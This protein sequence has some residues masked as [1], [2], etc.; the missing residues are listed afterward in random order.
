MKELFQYYSEDGEHWKIN[1]GKN[2]IS[3]DGTYD[4]DFDE[5]CIFTI[6]DPFD[7]PHNPGRAKIVNKKFLLD[8]LKS[9]FIAIN[10]LQKKTKKEERVNFLS[11]V[12]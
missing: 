12:F 1:D 10:E 5:E 6:K 11:S 7:K 8:Q 4:K 9:G 3:V 2:I